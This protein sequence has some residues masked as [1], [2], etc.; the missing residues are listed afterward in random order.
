M[1]I[2]PHTPPEARSIYD[3][4]DNGQF[5]LGLVMIIIAFLFGICFGILIEYFR[6]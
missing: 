6:R 3:D 4:R 5:V 1:Q 2:H